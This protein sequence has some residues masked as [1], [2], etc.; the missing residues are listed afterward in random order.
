[1]TDANLVRVLQ[2]QLSHSEGRKVG[3]ISYRTVAKSAESILLRID[4]L[5]SEGFDLAIVDA[6]SNDDLIRL[7][8]ALHNAPLVTATSGLALG[9]PLIWGFHPTQESS[10]LPQTEGY[11]AIVP[12]ICSTMTRGQ[13]LRFV[14][15]G[16]A[17]YALEPERLAANLEEKVAE[18]RA[19]AASCWRENPA[20]P[21]LIYSTADPTTVEAAQSQLGVE[22]A[23]AIVEH[24]LSLVAR[25]LVECGAGMLIIAGGG[26]F[27]SLRTGALHQAIA[28]QSTDRR[29]CTILLGSH[30]LQAFWTWTSCCTKIG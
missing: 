28:D 5:R 23:G 3:L 4:E 8:A 26:D 11:K 14:R 21:L 7:G 24:A 1:M 25:G 2:A 6:I 15:N 13:V 9:L 17:A 10:W 27:R 19:W 22:Q 18:A 30:P 16:G 12:G 20:L 29:R